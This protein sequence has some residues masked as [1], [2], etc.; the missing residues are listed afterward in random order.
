MP[1]IKIDISKQSEDT[2]RKLV[3][4]ITK[5]SAEVTGIREEA[6]IVFVNEYD[7]ESIGVGGELLSDGLPKGK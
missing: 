3:E 2:K 6:F 7:K 4:Q 1:C 5:V